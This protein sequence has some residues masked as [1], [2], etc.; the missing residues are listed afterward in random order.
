MTPTARRQYLSVL[1]MMLLVALATPVSA[2]DASLPGG[3]S[4]LNETHG[5]WAVACVITTEGERRQIRHCGLSQTQWHSQTRQRAL[6]IELR[7][8]GDGV[9]GA[10]ILPFG[11]ALASGITYQLDEGQAGAPQPFRTCLPAGCQVDIAF[12]ARTVEGL[13][14]SDILKVKASADGGREIVFSISLAGFSSAHERT[15]TLM[16]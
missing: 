10:L 5:A 14:V 4:T 15:V 3:A 16:Q 13:K 7:P 6:A 2:Q 11:L 8:E 9:S 12:D 1:T